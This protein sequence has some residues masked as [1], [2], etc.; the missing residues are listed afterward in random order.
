MLCQRVAVVRLTF[1]PETLSKIRL[2][3]DSKTAENDIAVTPRGSCANAHFE[4]CQEE[5][6]PK[7]GGIIGRLIALQV[8][9]DIRKKF[10]STMWPEELQSQRVQCT[11]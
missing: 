11:H 1:R 8:K 4:A 3:A 10:W 5:E 9:C 7:I 2:S 6:L